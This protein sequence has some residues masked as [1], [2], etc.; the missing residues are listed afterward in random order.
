MSTNFLN[1]N[2]DEPLNLVGSV[3]IWRR[4]GGAGQVT[5]NDETGSPIGIKY[6][7]DD[8]AEGAFD[9]FFF[10]KNLQGDIVA[11]YNAE[12]WVQA[13]PA[14]SR[15]QPGAPRQISCIPIGLTISSIRPRPF[16]WSSSNKPWRALFEPSQSAIKDSI[17]FFVS[18]HHRGVD[19]RRGQRRGIIDEDSCRLRKRRGEVPRRHRVA[20]QHPAL[21]TPK[22]FSRLSCRHPRQ[23]RHYARFYHA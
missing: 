14:A 21:F 4:A 6:R 20:K 19:K 7:T 22:G 12:E 18:L 13:L 3:P 8:Y 15:P 5:V 16:T 1:P 23:S 9:Y 11:I 2:Q 17:G 10:E